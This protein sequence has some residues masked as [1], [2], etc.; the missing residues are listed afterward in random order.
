MDQ[1]DFVAAITHLAMAAWGVV[2]TLFLLGR[3]RDQGRVRWIVAGYGISIISL[4]LASGLFHLLIYL[5][6]GP[7][8]AYREQAV[9]NYWLFQTLDKSAIFLLIAMSNVVVMAY[10]LPPSWQWWCIVFMLNAALL[11]ISVLWL[12]PGL[13][14]P[15]MVGIYAGMGIAGL[16]P[17]RQ[18][19]RVLCW[20][21]IGWVIL[22]ATCFLGGAAIEVARWPVLMPGWIGS[23]ELFHV[24]IM[25]GTYTHF[26]FVVRFVIPQHP[27]NTQRCGASRRKL[28]TRRL[29]TETESCWRPPHSLR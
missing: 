29:D 6:T 28:F 15:V 13:P 10:L 19:L 21:G 20:R 17:F 11:G 23:H 5:A 2:A 26:V 27:R 18:Y 25:A 7:A 12:F 14:H 3:T 16:F 1:R 22:F 8:S 24:A 9:N 4:Y